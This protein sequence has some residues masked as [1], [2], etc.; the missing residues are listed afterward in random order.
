MQEKRERRRKKN[1]TSNEMRS[2]ARKS[3]VAIREGKQK[4]D[5]KEN[6][7]KGRKAERDTW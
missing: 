2:R 1:R 5:G 4:G 3:I 7:N 6:R